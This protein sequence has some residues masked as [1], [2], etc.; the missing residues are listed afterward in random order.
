MLLITGLNQVMHYY[1]DAT[2]YKTLIVS[3]AIS[4]FSKTFNHADFSGDGHIGICDSQDINNVW[5]LEQNAVGSG[6][7]RDRDAIGVYRAFR[8]NE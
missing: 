8:N 4:S 2:E 1:A 3:K 6:Y 7:G 5:V